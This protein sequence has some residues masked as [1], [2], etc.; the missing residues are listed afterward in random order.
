[1]QTKGSATE[2]NLLQDVKYIHT[3]NLRILRGFMGLLRLFYQTNQL[4]FN[5]LCAHISIIVHKFY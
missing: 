1:M 2:L 4:V 5:L 3:S